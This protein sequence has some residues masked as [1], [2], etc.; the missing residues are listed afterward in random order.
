MDLMTAGGGKGKD[1]VS[2]R[3]SNGVRQASQSC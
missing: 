2:K 1:R 3:G